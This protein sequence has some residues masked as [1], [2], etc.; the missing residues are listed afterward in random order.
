LFQ[1]QGRHTQT[2]DLIQRYNTIIDTVETDPA[3]KI[4]IA[5]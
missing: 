2:A 3:L 4:D 5:G 1:K